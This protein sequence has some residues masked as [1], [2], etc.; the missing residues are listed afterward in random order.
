MFEK[1]FPKCLPDKDDDFNEL[2]IA[3]SEKGQELKNVDVMM[4]R[5]LGLTSY[6]RSA[7]EQLMPKLIHT[8]KKETMFLVKSQ[9]SDH[10][11]SLYEKIR[12]EEAE[13][14][15]RNKKNKAKKKDEEDEVSS[16][17]RIFS[18]ALCNFAFPADIQRPMPN[19]DSE[20][21]INEDNFDGI[22]KKE[23]M[24]RDDYNP[25]DEEN[26]KDDVSYQKKIAKALKELA[27]KDRNGAYTYLNMESLKLYS[28]KFLELLN[29]LQHPDNKGKHLIYSQFRT[30]EGIGIIRLILLSNGYAE[31]KVSKN[32][33]S[34]KWNIVQKI[35]DEEKP[36]FVLYTG[37]ESPEE[38]ELIRNIYNSNWDIVPDEITAQL[39]KQSK[40]NLY[41][42]IIKIFMI[43]ASGA[44]GISLK[45]TRFVHIMEPYWNMVRPKQVI[46]RARRI[47]S[48]EE[49]PKSLRSVKV[50][51]Y[52][53]VLTEEQKTS[54]K[55]I[56]LRIRDTSKMDGVTPVTTDETLFEIAS[57]KEHINNQVL[58]AV[59]SSSFDCNLYATKRSDEKLVCYKFGNIT[60]NDYSTRPNIDI[61]KSFKELNVKTVSWDATKITYKGKDYALNNDTNEVYDLESYNNA[62]SG[63]GELI[64]VA[65]IEKVNGKPQFTFV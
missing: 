30:I 40:N 57:L 2:F 41:G 37:T 17:Y 18:R 46:G 44:E 38:K 21:K 39:K 53:T 45:D 54:E 23:I 26:I 50:Y 19:K 61:D 65:E 12:K 16:T 58:D 24:N 6:F 9:M 52:L 49:L 55:N 33:S 29:N 13:Q 5:I 31:F 8:D 35:G 60:S 28:P 48:H 10:Q 15:K 25:E 59:K 62:V 51:M 42:E 20:G 47:C 11:F 22:K 27:K 56:E 43:T 34:G 32:A 36:K 1:S 14:D 3:D 7:Q 63:M 4:R 64:K